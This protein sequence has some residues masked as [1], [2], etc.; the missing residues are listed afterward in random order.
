[1]IANL[2]L[3]LMIGPGHDGRECPFRHGDLSRK[4]QIAIMPLKVANGDGSR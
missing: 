3:I 1:M 4:P 2:T